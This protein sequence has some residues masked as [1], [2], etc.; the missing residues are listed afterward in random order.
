MVISPALTG[1]AFREEPI[2]GTQMHHC[3]V[4]IK[5]VLPRPPLISRACPE[6]FFPSHICPKG[7]RK[8][9][10]WQKIKCHHLLNTPTRGSIGQEAITP[11]PPP[12]P[13]L[14]LPTYMPPPT[15]IPPASSLLASYSMSK[16]LCRQQKTSP[17]R[18]IFTNTSDRSRKMS[19]HDID[20][21]R[22]ELAWQPDVSKHLIVNGIPTM[23]SIWKLVIHLL[24][25]KKKRR[26]KEE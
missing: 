15:I 10:R 25:R 3:I 18:C 4:K 8:R 11:P 9:R 16:H 13:L 20:F 19:S 7:Q 17:R 23:N 12:P 14:S 24:P 6:S 22:S 5:F 26:A 1:Y 21:S 2:P